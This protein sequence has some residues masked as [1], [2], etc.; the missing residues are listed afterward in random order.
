MKNTANYSVARKFVLIYRAMSNMLE[1]PSFPKLRCVIT[2]NLI[3]KEYTEN[4]SFSYVVS[5]F[6]S[7]SL[8]CPTLVLRFE[9]FLHTVRLTFS[10]CLCLLVGYDGE[11]LFSFN[12][13]L[14]TRASIHFPYSHLPI[15]MAQHAADIV[16]QSSS[17]VS[18]PHWI[19]APS[20]ARTPRLVELLF[21]MVNGSLIGA[22]T[23][24][25]QNCIVVELT[26]TI[27]HTAILF[28]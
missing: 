3:C 14:S 21:R 25:F 27:K 11:H 1:E 13:T 4:L 7:S 15:T 10:L 9:W 24:P 6:S 26:F 16:S 2:E 5:C 22:S 12:C 28:K 20:E 17:S 8:F 23:F 18:L 19:P